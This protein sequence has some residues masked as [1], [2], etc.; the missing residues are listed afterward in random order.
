MLCPSWKLQG[1][2][3]YYKRDLLAARQTLDYY[4]VLYYD[5]G[6]GPVVVPQPDVAGSV[7]VL[8]E[9]SLMGVGML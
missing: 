2:L 7:N 4:L 3:T 9:A 1:F 6:T 8:E 5:I